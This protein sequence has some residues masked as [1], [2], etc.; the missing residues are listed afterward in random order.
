MGAMMPMVPQEV[1]VAKP[2]AAPM[3]KMMAGRNIRRSPTL[4]M[5]LLTKVSGVH[6]IAGEGAQGP[7][8]GQDQDGGDH[9]DEALGNGF[10]GLLEADG[11]A[12]PE[13]ERT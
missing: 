13:V 2:I 4:A 6:G 8:E 11:A 1:P 7:G 10:H 5:A 3:M 12:Q 9:L